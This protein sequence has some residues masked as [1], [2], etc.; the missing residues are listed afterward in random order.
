MGAALDEARLRYLLLDV[1]GT[2]TPVEFVYQVLFPYA[3]RALE[4]F[5]QERANDG[6]VSIEIER[7]RAEHASNAQRGLRP[8]E[9]QDSSAE[10]RVDSACHYVYWLMDRDSK[11]STLKALQGRIWEE[12]Y[13]SGELQGDV[14]PDVAPAFSRWRGKDKQIAIFSSG[15]ILAQRLLFETTASGDL[16]S[17][18]AAHFDTTTGPKAAA[19]SYRRIA[20]ALNGAPRQMLFISDTIAELDAAAASGAQTLLCV[21]PGCDVPSETKHPVIYGFDGVLP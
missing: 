20:D 5:L 6:K 17:F 8:P 18:I 2:T 3:R 12:G 11:S 16:S 13:R 7:L 1:E 9:W 21:R 10:I 14:Y 4:S 19:D 15:S